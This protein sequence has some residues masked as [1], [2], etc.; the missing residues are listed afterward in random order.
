[1]WKGGGEQREGGIDIS[2]ASVAVLDLTPSSPPGEK[3]HHVK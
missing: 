3:A 2:E 1:M